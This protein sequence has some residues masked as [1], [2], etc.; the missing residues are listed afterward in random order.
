MNN[1]IK[2]FAVCVAA[3]VMALG[4]AAPT[5][6]AKTGTGPCSS[7]CSVGGSPGNGLPPGN[8]ATHSINNGGPPQEV[9][10]DIDHEVI[11]RGAANELVIPRPIVI[12][13]PV[14]ERDG[15]FLPPPAEHHIGIP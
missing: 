14:D 2:F 12:H 9:I 4:V 3:P 13:R 15:F 11:N 1:T 8:G 6:W 5:A 10:V 7:N